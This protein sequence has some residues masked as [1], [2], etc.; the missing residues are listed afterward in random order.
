MKSDTQLQHDVLTE[1]EHE[2][3]IE[4][5]KIGITAKNGVVTLSGTVRFQPGGTDHKSGCGG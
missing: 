3:S 2:P 4:A 5:S 1:L